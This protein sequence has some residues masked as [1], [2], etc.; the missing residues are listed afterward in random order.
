MD[1]HD[2]PPIELF[3]FC[4]LL[5]TAYHSTFTR[6]EIMSVFE[7]SGTWPVDHAKL[8]NVPRPSD[9]DD[10]GRILSVDELENL[11]LQRRLHARERILR[12]DV[13]IA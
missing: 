3:T 8:L 6:T 12:K 4:R 5:R 11:Y 2:A 7:K 9:A 10:L 1:L 13:T